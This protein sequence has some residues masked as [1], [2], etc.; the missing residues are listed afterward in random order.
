MDPA[1]ESAL[2]PYE[3]DSTPDGNGITKHCA[4]EN[5]TGKLQQI[6]Q[7]EKSQFL[8]GRQQR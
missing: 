5:L 8:H 7:A 3:I 6:L 1:R 4:E 2:T